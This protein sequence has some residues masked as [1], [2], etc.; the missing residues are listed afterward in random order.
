MST[1]QNIETISEH[2][3]A[4]P[5]YQYIYLP[6]IYRI[7][8]QAL[9]R[10]GTKRAENK[11]KTLL[12]QIWGAYYAKRPDFHTLSHDLHIHPPNEKTIEAILAM[13]ASTKERLSYL[14][15][16][17]ENIFA[18]T[19]KP[20][21]VLDI[22][23]GMNPFT[24]GWMHLN[25]NTTY[26]A[27]DIDTQLIAFLQEVCPKLFPD[28]VFKITAGDT[29]EE[30][31]FFVDVAFMFKIIPLLQL[32]QKIDVMNVLEKQHA[33]YL[34]ITFPLRSISGKHVGMDTFYPMQFENMCAKTSWEIGKVTFPTELVY[35]IKK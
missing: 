27:Y 26:Y 28:I 16:F 12:H 19:G 30:S 31:Q 5:K 35:V 7:V 24:I 23:C 11:A 34:I 22:G 10:Y 13:H 21:S 8:A 4:S 1:Q 15:I 9:H 29:F 17:Y 20:Q 33:T 32:Q 6:T 3:H 25:Q 18:I 14:D 2:I